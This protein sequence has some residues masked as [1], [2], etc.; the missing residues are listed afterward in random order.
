M[1]VKSTQR[2][3]RKEAEDKYWILDA[4]LNKKKKCLCHLSDTDLEDKLEEM[5]DLAR[6]G[7]GFENY[8]ITEKDDDK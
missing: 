5:N 7:E 6:G 8:I 2:I 3:T 1:G 4:E